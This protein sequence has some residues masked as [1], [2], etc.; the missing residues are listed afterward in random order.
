M[1]IWQLSEKQLLNAVRSARSLVR[2]F[3][4][5]GRRPKAEAFKIN[6]HFCSILG[7]E[8]KWCMYVFTGNCGGGRTIERNKNRWEDV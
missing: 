7:K 4:K 2:F 3:N 1:K 6:F 8:G 5:S